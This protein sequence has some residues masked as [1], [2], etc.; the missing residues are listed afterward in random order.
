MGSPSRD[1]L[2][3]DDLS[4]EDSC[5]RRVTVMRARSES[6][7]MDAA[8][9]STGTAA[10]TAAARSRR[11]VSARAPARRPAASRR[12]ART[13]GMLVATYME[14]DTASLRGL[15]NSCEASRGRDLAKSRD[16]LPSEGGLHPC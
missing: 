12:Q 1:S 9:V 2:L 13:F 14:E 11:R 16:T 10:V 15:N 3:L 8:T 7:P 5:A 6:S 4:P